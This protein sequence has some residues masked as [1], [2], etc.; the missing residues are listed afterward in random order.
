MENSGKYVRNFRDTSLG[1]TL[2]LPIV[3]VMNEDGY[4]YPDIDPKA[5]IEE[6]AMALLAVNRFNG[7]M[8]K[9]IR[10]YLD[11]SRET[12]GKLVGV[13]KTSVAAWES[14]RRKI[15]ELG[16]ENLQRIKV[17]LKSKVFQKIETRALSSSYEEADISMDVRLDKIYA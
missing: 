9:F 1:F 16:P 11:I 13:S 7:G 4:E 15:V 2:V 6:G 3:R 14:D 10:K 8:I 5:L 12:F 17:T